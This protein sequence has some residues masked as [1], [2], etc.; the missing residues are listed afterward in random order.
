MADCYVIYSFEADDPV[1]DP[2]YDVGAYVAKGYVH[3][4]IIAEVCE[5]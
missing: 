3:N 4:A 1:I 5:D 2:E